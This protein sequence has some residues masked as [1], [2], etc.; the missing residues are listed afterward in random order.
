MLNIFSDLSTSFT[1]WMLLPLRKDLHHL[2]PIEQE[3]RYI[4]KP[5]R[6]CWWKENFPAPLRQLNPS[7]VICNHTLFD[8]LQAPLQQVFQNQYT[9]AT[10]SITHKHRSAT[11]FLLRLLLIKNVLKWHTFILMHL[12]TSK[13]WWWW[14]WLSTTHQAL[15]HASTTCYSDTH[16]PQAVWFHGKFKLTVTIKCNFWH[17]CRRKLPPEKLIHHWFS[18]LKKNRVHFEA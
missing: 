3:G 12:T 15:V 1:F 17:K 16:P 10:T 2:V 5:S 11:S 7:Q 8:K 6:T 9:A 14:W 4:P 13:L 18:E